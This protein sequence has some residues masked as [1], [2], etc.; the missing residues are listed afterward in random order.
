MSFAF[1]EG[2]FAWF[3]VMKKMPLVGVKI[4][5]CICVF[6]QVIEKHSAARVGNCESILKSRPGELGNCYEVRLGHYIQGT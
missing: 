1:P 4:F 6:V 3:P 5:Q 2:G